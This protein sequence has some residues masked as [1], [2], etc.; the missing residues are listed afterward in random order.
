M[1]ALLLTTYGTVLVAELLGDKTL[2]TLGSLATRFR[3]GAILGGAVA[4]FALKMLVAVL[5]GRV[6]ATCPDALVAAV[7]AATFLVMAVV[8]WRKRPGTPPADAAPPRWSRATVISFAAIFFPEWGD[9]GQL[10]AAMLVAQH[11]APLVIWSGAVLAMLTKACLAVSLGIGLRRWVPRDGLRW[12][13][14][15][16]CLAMALLAAFRIEL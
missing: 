10:A 4:A 7:S 14:V 13:S 5:F 1:I 6:L 9:P 11:G 2:Y 16:V 12:V 3:L 15:A 8:L